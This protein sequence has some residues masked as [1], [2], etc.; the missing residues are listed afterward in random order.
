MSGDLQQRDAKVCW[1]PFTQHQIDPLPMPVVS[2]HNATLVLEDGSTRIDAISS[3]WSILHGHCRPELAEVLARQAN[4]LDHVLFAGCTHQPAVELAELLIDVAPDSLSRVF[5]S[6]NGSTAVEIGLKAAY[7]SWVRRG[8][9]QRTTFIALEHSYHGDTFGAMALG[10]PVPFFSEFEPFLFG[11]ERVAPNADSLRKCL[12]QL[13]EQACAF[14]VEPLVQGAAGMQM[15]SIEFLQAARELCDEFGVYFIA[16]EVMT[17]F[18]RTG[19]LFSC[20]TA[21][22]EPDIMAVAKGLSGGILP[23]SATLV[24]EA[25]YQHFLDDDRAKAFFHGH[26]FTGNP[27]GCAVALRSL[28]LCVS[29]QTPK[30]LQEIG[31]MVECALASLSDHPRIEIRRCGGI[32]AIEIIATDGGYLAHAGDILRNACRELDDVLLRPL[33]NVLYAMPPACTTEDECQVIADAMIKVV[34]QAVQ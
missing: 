9:P 22:I 3:W 33:G 8:Q 2:A 4:T 17:G 12:E 23:L 32:V 15:H 6:D 27:L 16:D 1:H 7:Q 28:Q 25:I 26:T 18:G 21:G 20:Q 14:I 31:K 13:G 34:R 5:Y 24:S 29:E 30:R 19:N 10:D 11:V